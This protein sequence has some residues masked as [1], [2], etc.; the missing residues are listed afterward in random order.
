MDEFAHSHER[1]LRALMMNGLDGDADA[2]H[3]LLERLT[4]HLR[5]YY[6]R[7]FARIGH[8]PAE[9]EDLLQ[10]TL[11]AVH[12]HRQPVATIHALVPCDRTLQ[13]SGLSAADE[14][15]VQGCAP[16]KPARA[17][18]GQRHWGDRE[19]IGFGSADVEHFV[20]GETGDSVRE[21]GRSKR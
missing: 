8:G 1:E 12:T 3:Q 18:G 10:E 16:G 21:T 15:F 14:V 17:D 13:I 9:A 2:Y 11:I 4:G 5:A 7:R 19:L 6:R 20:Q